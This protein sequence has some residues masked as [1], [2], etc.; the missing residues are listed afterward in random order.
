M[1]KISCDVCLDLLPLVKDGIA[2]EDSRK[3]VMDHLEGCSPCREF[4]NLDYEEEVEMDD[5]RVLSSIKKQL[6]FIGLLAIIIG[7]I[8]GVALFDGIG[9]FHNIL[10]MPLIGVL[11]YFLL[12]KK[13][14]YIPISLFIFVYIWILIK[15][16]AEGMFSYTPFISVLAHPA[17]WAGIYTGLSIL[18]ILI[19]F[20]LNI[21]FKKE[22]VK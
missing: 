12:K 19:G 11:G 9:M 17:Y 18:G 6:Y 7:S 8:L 4:Y 1:D 3:A 14:Y 21:A 2:S 16:I 5:R 13:S 15:S 20:L 22:E 10:I